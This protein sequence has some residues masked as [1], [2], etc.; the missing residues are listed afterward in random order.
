VAINEDYILAMSQGLAYIATKNTAAP[1]TIATAPAAGWTDLGAIST[2]GL[3]EDLSHTGPS[4]SAGAP[5][6]C[7]A[8]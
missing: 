7:S 2:D 3:T 1:A 5:S 6:R 8:P 4:S